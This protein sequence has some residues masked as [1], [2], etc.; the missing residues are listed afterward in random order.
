MEE[1]GVDVLTDKISDADRRLLKAVAKGE[2]GGDSSIATIAVDTNIPA[3]QLAVQLKNLR[4]RDLVDT[5][6]D[7][8]VEEWTLTD[9]GRAL[10]EK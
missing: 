10:I 3:E 5:D 6:E 8:G 9:E 4:S 1:T 7:E 2:R